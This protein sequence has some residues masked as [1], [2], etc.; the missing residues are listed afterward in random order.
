MTINHKFV[1]AIPEKLEDNVLYISIEHDTCLHLCCCGCKNEVVTPLSPH[2]WK[3]TYDGES[4]SLSPSIGNW[5][6]KCQSHYWI[7]SN[8]IV[9]A[10]MWSMDEIEE[11]R[12]EDY[13]KKKEHFTKSK[14]KKKW[15]DKL[16]ESLFS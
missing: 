2:D 5:N 8:N 11:N 7:K 4:V 10:N 15:Y 1:E 16:F 9:W 3:L 12:K 13:Q 14:K 6:F